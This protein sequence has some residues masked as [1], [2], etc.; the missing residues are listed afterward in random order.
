LCNISLLGFDYCGDELNHYEDIGMEL[1]TTLMSTAEGTNAA[2]FIQIFTNPRGVNNCVAPGFC[3]WSI[4]IYSQELPGS[5][6]CLCR[7]W[8]WQGQSNRAMVVH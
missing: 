6:L 3:L 8:I 2:G 7:R 1:P 4:L 5:G